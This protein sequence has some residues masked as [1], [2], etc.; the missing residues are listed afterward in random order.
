MK[1]GKAKVAIIDNAIDV[2]GA[3]KAIVAYA[4]YVKKDFSFL[5]VL[6]TDSRAVAYVE[7]HGFTVFEVPFLEI[8]KNWKNLMFYFPK[9]LTNAIRLVRILNR[10]GVELVHVNDFYNIAPI[11]AKHL[12]GKFKLV[13]HVRFMPD[14]FP[15][16]L[17]KL[18]LRLSLQSTEAIICVS[19]A[20]RRLLPDHSKI[21]LIYDGLLPTQAPS[22][23][24]SEKQE[25]I[26]LLYLA[27]YIPGKGQNYALDAFFLAFQENPKLRLRFVGGD[28]GLKKNKE[29]KRFLIQRA[30][31]LQ[32]QDVISFAGQTYTPENEITAANIVLNFSESE[33]FSLT[34]LESLRLG[35][36]LIATDSGGPAELFVHKE[37]GWLVPNK[38]IQAMK[39][40]ILQ[41]SENWEIRKKFIRNSSVFVRR[42]F[43]PSNTFER[44]KAMYINVL[45]KP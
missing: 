29:F 38:D 1:K 17:M 33:S 15:S 36:P 31:D 35:T 19:E 28:M 27:H 40:A 14:R 4:E 43:A 39:I 32:L 13:S 22:L 2:T 11:L 9:L 12:G 7:E 41:L 3:I 18:W 44:L 26:R 45:N 24:V 30:E 23:L 34:C 21:N 16:G 20:V 6:P 25:C 37:S 42:K 10:Q 8:S 5:F